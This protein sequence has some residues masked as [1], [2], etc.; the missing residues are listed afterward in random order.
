MKCPK[1]GS[2][3]VEKLARGT[4]VAAAG[5][6][7]GGILVGA[8]TRAATGSITGKLLDE[9]V[10]DNRKCHNCDYEWHN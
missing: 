3:N 7:I 6:A 1:C 8:M 2:E 4:K 5:G 9:T 10:L